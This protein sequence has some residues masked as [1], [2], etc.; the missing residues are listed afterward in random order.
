MKFLQANIEVPSSSSS[1]HIPKPPF[2][3]LHPSRRRTQH[4]HNGLHQKQ[5][6]RHSQN[7]NFNRPKGGR[8]RRLE[9]EKDEHKD[10]ESEHDDK[11]D[12][13]L[14]STKSTTKIPPW[15]RRSCRREQLLENAKG[16]LENSLRT[17]ERA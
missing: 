4:A 13:R 3:L 9:D 12:E 7:Q 16:T 6:R 8:V 17:R 14:G 15:G 2:A 5:N 1:F 10:Q 11:E